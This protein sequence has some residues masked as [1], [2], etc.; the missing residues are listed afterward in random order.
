M[1]GRTGIALPYARRGRDRA[2]SFCSRAGGCGQYQAAAGVFLA[3][4]RSRSLIAAC[5]RGRRACSPSPD[6]VPAGQSVL[7]YVDPATMIGAGRC[8]RLPALFALRVALIG[9]AAFARAAPRRI[10]GKRA[11]HGE[12]NWMSSARRQSCFRRPAASSSANA[13]ASTR[14]CVGDR[15]FRADEPETWGAGGKA[16][17][18][19]FDGSFGSSHGIVFAG[20]GG[21]KTT[22]VTIPTALKWG[23]GL[24]V[25]DPSN[26]VAPMVIEHRR[27]AGRDVFVLDPTDAGD[28][29][30]RARLDRP[31]RRHQRRG[32]RSRSR[33]GS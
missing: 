28:R 20:S 18:L 26:E 3:A 22:S 14:T 31:L 9:N 2:S 4:R 15:A 10:R 8:D 7:S 29:L 25:L 13:I 6:S 32:H 17:L 24:V 27:R 5:S 30:Q 1:L 12:A 21:F 11:I 23:G 19:C 33:P 16:P